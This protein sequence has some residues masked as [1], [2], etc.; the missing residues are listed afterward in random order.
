M[1][2]VAPRIAGGSKTHIPPPGKL[3]L[4]WCPVSFLQTC[5]WRQFPGERYIFTLTHTCASMH[6]GT[7]V[8]VRARTHTH[9]LAHT[10]L[11]MLARVHTCML[12][13][14]RVSVSACGRAHTNTCAGFASRPVADVALQAQNLAS[15]QAVSPIS[16]EANRA[17]LA[18]AV[19]VVVGTT[20]SAMAVAA[21]PPRTPLSWYRPSVTV[22]GCQGPRC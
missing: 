19:C 8:L 9:M 11:H 22:G 5:L 18:S 7:H 6:V 13:H 2:R 21:L 16:V 3:P 20:D 10:H 15:L 17:A 12:S 14:A 1:G 4:P